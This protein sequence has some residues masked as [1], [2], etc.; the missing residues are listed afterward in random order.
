MSKSPNQKLKM[1]YIMRF[2]LEKTDEAHPVSVPGII[3]HLAANGI[4]AERK[5]IYDDIA[6][7]R[8]FGMDIEQKSGRDGGYYAAGHDFE[9]AELKL[10][11]DSV[12]ASKF[13]TEKKTFSLIKKIEGLTNIYDAGQLR[14]Q[15]YV[16]GRIKTMNESIYYNV[17][18]I[19]SA[20]SQDREIGFKYFE[21][22]PEKKRVYRRGGSEYAVS[23]YA[24]TWDNENYYMIGYDRSK[25]EIRHYRVD[26]MSS[27]R[28]LDEPRQGKESFT[29]TD[30]AAYTNRVFG[31]FSGE[32]E[33]V[34]FR[35][36]NH[37]AGAVMDR[38]GKDV[39][40]VP[41][42]EGYFSFSAQV[43]VSPQFFAWVCGFGT[44]MKITAPESVV[45]RMGGYVRA[46]AES[47]T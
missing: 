15:V 39:I 33:R 32:R 25:G 18:E 27:I 1:L 22:S 13:I 3:S 17:D 20:I 5:S 26:K 35:A 8:L 45:Q 21:Y 46:I 7:L 10:L 14:R 12:Q 2:L 9:L 36:A 6:A 24:L 44:E 19:H 37:L 47:Y 4:S 28:L 41:E 38:F 16:S 30:P 23:P 34:V 42:A 43:A 40:M 31:M 11:V 29:G